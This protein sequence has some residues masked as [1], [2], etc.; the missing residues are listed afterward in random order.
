MVQKQ[1]TIE[2][3]GFQYVLGAGTVNGLTFKMQI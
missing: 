3:G 1:H 2:E